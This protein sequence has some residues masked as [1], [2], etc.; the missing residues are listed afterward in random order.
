MTRTYSQPHYIKNIDEITVTPE[1]STQKNNGSLEGQISWAVQGTRL[2][3][4]FE[5]VD[6][7]TKYKKTTDNDLL[8]A[9]K[10]ISKLKATSLFLR[11]SI[12]VHPKNGHLF[13]SLM[14]L[15][16]ISLTELAVG[17]RILLLIGLNNECCPLPWCYNKIQ[18]CTINYCSQ[19]TEFTRRTWRCNL[20]PGID[21]RNF[22]FTIL[23]YELLLILITAALLKL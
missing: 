9:I 16:L 13:Y 20:P 19:N 10:S 1:R 3:L 14:L 23:K 11:F 22:T 17:G 8:Q 21:W 15:T 12:L 4:S 6:L 2:D 5:M 18:C 7:S